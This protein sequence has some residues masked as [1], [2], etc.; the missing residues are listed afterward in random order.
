MRQRI[1]HATD[2]GDKAVNETVKRLFLLEEIRHSLIIS[3][4]TQPSMIDNFSN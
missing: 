3:H 2:K 4:P 1:I